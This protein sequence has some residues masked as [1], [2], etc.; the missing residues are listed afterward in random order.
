MEDYPEARGSLVIED[1]KL[2]NFE[3]KE[4]SS[5]DYKISNA[6]E[7]SS[8]D[9]GNNSNTSD[10]QTISNNTNVG[11]DAQNNSNLNGIENISDKQIIPDV[12]GTENSSNDRMINNAID[13]ETKPYNLSSSDAIANK[14][15]SDIK[16]TES[17]TNN[18][19][20]FVFDEKTG[21]NNQMVPD[22]ITR[23]T[24][25]ERIAEAKNISNRD[26]TQDETVSDCQPI[27]EDKSSSENEEIVEKVTWQSYMI[28]ALIGL[29]VTCGIVPYT[30][31]QTIVSALSKY[32]VAIVNS[33]LRVI[34][35]ILVITSVVILI[36]PNLPGWKYCQKVEVIQQAICTEYYNGEFSKIELEPWKRESNDVRNIREMYIEQTFYTHK[37]T[38]KQSNLLEFFNRQDKYSQRLLLVA[39][40]GSG[41]TTAIKNVMSKWCQ[42]QKPIFGNTANSYIHHIKY[43]LG[44]NSFGS[45][46]I[47]PKAYAIIVSYVTN[48]YT[49]LEPKLVFAFEFRDIINLK[50]LA[51]TVL[52]R[53]LVSV[54]GISLEDVEMILRNEMRNILLILDGWDEYEKLQYVT[55]T[56]PEID[57]IIHRREYKNINL[58][59][60]T[61]P[62]KSSALLN[63][64]LYA[65]QKVSMSHFK[66]PQDRDDFIRAFFPGCCEEDDLIEALNADDVA[67]AM[68]IQ[69]QP[70]MLLYICNAWIYD[71]NI[72]I[73]RLKDK[74]LFWDT[75]WAMMLMTYNNKYPDKPMTR[76]DLERK[77][78]QFRDFMLQNEDAYTSIEEYYDK[79]GEDDEDLMYFGVYSTET[80]DV[81]PWHEQNTNEQLRTIGKER[82]EGKRAKVTYTSM[83]E[84]EKEQAI[85]NSKWTY[86]TQLWDNYG[87]LG[88]LVL[89][90]LLV[91]LIL[92]ISLGPLGIILSI[93]FLIVYRFFRK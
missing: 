29:L 73:N 33:L 4:N 82:N 17:I 67:V 41:K 14:S 21:S 55:G 3:N 56:A 74:N 50:T 28:S 63:V 61:R 53:I 26:I 87:T 93:I 60:T 6:Q 66:V 31:Q 76:Q 88:N 46:S 79:F 89:I 81:I 84:H 51:D 16:D 49:E 45:D 20:I 57:A 68:E 71:T 18:Q 39:E 25:Q 11:S 37:P 59:V 38:R 52:Q 7:T 35:G 32:S 30:Y 27:R 75:M 9:Q 8:E 12:C 62:W 65:Y 58:I 15:R 69:K 2:C 13:K 77:R 19:K 43:A 92:G 34:L 42:A 44:I 1:K 86:V 36:L 48:S 24:I 80:F 10:E 23:K 64:P 90:F 47:V 91:L 40:Q 78:N 83:F 5:D 70:R 72:R 22:N 54:T 85:A